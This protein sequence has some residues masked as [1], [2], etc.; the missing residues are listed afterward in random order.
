MR[1][2]VTGHLSQGARTSSTIR[3]TSKR[4]STLAERSRI[5]REL[6]D[7]LEQ[8]LAGVSLHLD[9]AVRHIETK[10]DASKSMMQRASKLLRYSREE[11]RRSVMDLRSVA[12][13]Q[14]SFAAA[15]DCLFNHLDQDMR[16]Q[17]T[18]QTSREERRLDSRT[19]HDLPR[20]VQEAVNNAM[21]HG[22]HRLSKF[23][24]TFG[25]PTFVWRLAM[26]ELALILK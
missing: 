5:A 2:I 4:E 23:S 1:G 6:H 8:D 19:E 16:D 15:L 3:E 20:I 13:G 17:V 25:I 24:W 11:A 18:I 22:R 10:P 14:P 9:T 12:L 7:T 21:A 26:M